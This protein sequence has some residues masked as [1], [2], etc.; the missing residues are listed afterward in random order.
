MNIF[1]FLVQKKSFFLN[2][3]GIC[4]LPK[5]TSLID[6]LFEITLVKHLSIYV[7]ILIMCKQDRVESYNFHPFIQM[8]KC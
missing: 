1:R 7:S 5:L 2:S 4:T 8:K 3:D 6:D